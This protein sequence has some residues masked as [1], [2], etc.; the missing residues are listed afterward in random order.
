V[1]AFAYG[2]TPEGVAVVSPWP[3]GVQE[4]TETVT[5]YRADGYPERL[6]P[7]ERIFSLVSA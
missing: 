4:L 3:L 1:G 7:V 6:D 2:V 5:A